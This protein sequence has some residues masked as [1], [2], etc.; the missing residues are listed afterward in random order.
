MLGH[1]EAII[2]ALE[3][4][5][6]L[7]AGRPT[8]RVIFV[9]FMIIRHYLSMQVFADEE[10]NKRTK[11]TPAVQR[12]QI[13]SPSTGAK[14]QRWFI[15]VERHLSPP[16]ALGCCLRRRRARGLRLGRTRLG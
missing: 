11:P 6:S 12:M 1:E 7:L 14:G 10:D 8:I 13:V 16:L 9:A 2:H 4:C 5:S 3:S 15:A